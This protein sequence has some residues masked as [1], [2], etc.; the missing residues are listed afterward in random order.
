MTAAAPAPRRGRS[1]GVGKLVALAV[2]A[3]FVGLLAYGLI[4]QAPDS[5]IDDALARR[6][7]SPAPGF[8]L[9]RLNDGQSG[10]LAPVWDRA[11]ADGR[12]SL[13]ELG[14]TPV[15]VNFWASWCIPC[16]EEAPLLERA[17][18]SVRRQ[19][20]LFV[21]INMQDLSDD[22]RGFIDRFG[23]TFPNVRDQGDATSR[24]WGARGIPETFF[25]NRRGQVVGHV[26]GVVTP[27]QLEAGV[28]AAR[29]SRPMGPQIGGDQRPSR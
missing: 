28:T 25:I 7:A 12:V 14:G 10:P 2:L 13:T 24:R 27:G 23:L 15:I 26:I 17:W 1:A 22:A 6:E 8:D 5:T 9:P 19:G 18:R 11:A 29:D 3:L 21:G 4:A 20:V 16:R